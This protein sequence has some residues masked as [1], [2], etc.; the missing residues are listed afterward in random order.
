M[1][2]RH[3]SWLLGQLRRDG[4]PDLLAHLLLAAFDAELLTALREQGR[5]EAAVRDAL[6]TMVGA[7][8][9]AG[10]EQGVD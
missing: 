5:T 2:H 6:A 9:P 7:L 10:S 8:V 1:W 4:D 3:V